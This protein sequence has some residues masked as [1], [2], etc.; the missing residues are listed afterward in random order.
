MKPIRRFW[1][2]VSNGEL[3]LVAAA[4]SFSTLLSLI[5]FLAVSLATIQYIGGLETLYP[6][7]EA[8]AL[9]YFSGPIGAEG[10]RII[11]SVF[12][13]IHAGRMGGFG[14]VALVLT[15][16]LMIADMERGFHRIWNLPSRRPLYK[17]I[18][19]YWLVLLL[20]PAGLAVYVAV[21]SMKI[22]SGAQSIIPLPTLNIA[23]L[24]LTLYFIYKMVPNTKVHFLSAL[25]GAVSATAGLILLFRSFKWITQNV[26]VW[27][28]LWGSFAAIPALL[29]WILLTWYVV[30][31]GAALSA[32]FR[33]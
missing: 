18:L 17:R 6:K 21:T 4:L 20:F 3:Q 2:L 27:G 15:A 8:A 25:V 32:S 23:V 10:T 14:A 33:K 22:F 16:V 26:F 1:D 11:R 13:R 30:L 12:H 24:L 31:I 9:E 29:I 5:P 28:K 7:I 19:N